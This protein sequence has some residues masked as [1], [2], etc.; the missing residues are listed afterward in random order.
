MFAR[1]LL[2]HTCSYRD[3]FLPLFK[4]WHDLV[5]LIL[6][7]ILCIFVLMFI[8]TLSVYSCGSTG[9]GCAGD[10]DNDDNFC[11]SVT[12][13]CMCIRKYCVLT[14]YGDCEGLCHSGYTCKKIE[15]ESDC[16]CHQDLISRL[17]SLE[18]RHLVHQC[19]HDNFKFE[20]QYIKHHASNW[21]SWNYFQN[22]SH[23]KEATH[24]VLEVLDITFIW[25]TER[26][27]EALWLNL[28]ASA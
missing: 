18:W 17:A 27:F 2:S 23:W 19:R 6:I 4:L 15:G 8:P 28:L 12:G 26:L 21:K 7:E 22:A 13:S 16:S 3:H 1:S 20:F 5:L 24:I 25:P 9:H 11:A 14:P 10:C